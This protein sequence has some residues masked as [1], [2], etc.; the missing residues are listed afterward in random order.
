MV[1]LDIYLAEVRG[2]KVLQSL[3][4]QSKSYPCK[5]LVISGDPSLASDFKHEA[6]DFLAK[7][8]TSEDLLD[9]VRYLLG[10]EPKQYL[11]PIVG[12]DNE[13]V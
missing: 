6:D 7:P 9:K 2:D 3:N 11:E 5:V 13:S 10:I 1:V 8:F 4:Q 12:N